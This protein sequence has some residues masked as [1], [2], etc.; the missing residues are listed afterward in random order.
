MGDA[1]VALVA[2]GSNLASP[3]G[4]PAETVAAALELLSGLGQGLTSSLLW[5]SPSWPPGGPDYVN[6]AAAIETTLPPEALLDRL[7]GIEATFGRTREARWGPRV[8]DLDLLAWGDAVRPDAATQEA[9]RGLDSERQGRE[10]PD[11]LILPH[12]RMQDRGFVLMPLAE[13]APDW[14]H[15]LIGRSVREMLEALP[16]EAREGIAP[17]SAG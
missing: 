1:T 8:L 6:A 11:R 7:H 16:P 17:L 2:L 15:P 9:W 13:V 3:R 5:K 10:A 14:R 12:P 4:T